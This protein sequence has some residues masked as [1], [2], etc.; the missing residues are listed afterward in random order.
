[1]WFDD[2]NDLLPIAPGQR[3]FFLPTAPDPTGGRFIDEIKQTVETPYAQPVRKPILH[4]TV[5]GAISN[6]MA[7][8]PIINLPPLTTP[9]EEQR[10]ISRMFNPSTLTVSY[11]MT[12]NEPAFVRHNRPAFNP[13]SMLPIVDHDTME[14][15]HA[16]GFSGGALGGRSFPQTYGMGE[17]GSMRRDVG[18]RYNFINQMMDDQSK[19]QMFA[20]QQNALSD[21]LGSGIQSREKIAAIKALE[22]AAKN[23]V[24]PL[25]R[26][27]IE[28]A[29]SGTGISKSQLDDALAASLL[30]KINTPEDLGKLAS[31]VGAN[32]NYRSLADQLLR[33]KGIN[34]Q[35][36]SERMADLIRP[37]WYH[38]FARSAGMPYAE[39]VDPQSLEPSRLAEF[40]LL[41]S[42]INASR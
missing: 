9:M 31:K 10:D 39:S 35:R 2:I 27:I 4:P 16:L 23:Q 34:R 32:T 8:P 25:S 41:Q 37:P 28:E 30:D 22:E 17:I 21:R 19:M 18:Q 20:L 3:R 12:G 40:N 1:M 14:P 36:L 38:R 33:M 13:W 7:N 42:L 15:S 6:S 26:A 24:S 5:H 11:G 29:V